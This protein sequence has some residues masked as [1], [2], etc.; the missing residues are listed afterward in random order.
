[1]VTSVSCAYWSYRGSFYWRT[2]RGI[3]PEY[4]RRRWSLK[5]FEALVLSGCMR[6]SLSVANA[7]R[8][9]NP[10]NYLQFGIS[11]NF[12]NQELIYLVK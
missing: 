12:E 2:Q 1:M 3:L 6:Y 5:S 4:H 10:L 9:R 11:M 7:K 8:V